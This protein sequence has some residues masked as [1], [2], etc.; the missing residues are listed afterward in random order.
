MD[1]TI[2]RDPKLSK[3]DHL[4]VLLA[5]NDR[6]ALSKPLQRAIKDAAFAGRADESITVLSSEPKKTT[7]VGLGKRDALSI[8]SVRA[9]LYSVAKMAKRLRDRSITVLLPY[10]IASLDAEQTTRVVADYLGQSD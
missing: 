1:V 5:E 4:F 7:L 8:R 9:A 3:T 6:P 2:N 10:T